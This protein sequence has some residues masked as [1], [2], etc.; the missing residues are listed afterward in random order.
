MTITHVI[1]QAI[2]LRVT[3]ANLALFSS[4][5]I[6]SSTCSASSGSDQETPVNQILLPA[7]DLTWRIHLIELLLDHMVQPQG[8]QFGSN[9]PPQAGEAVLLL[10][11]A[12]VVEDRRVCQGRTA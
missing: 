8:A 11:V 2:S 12:D 4:S 3:L 7:L 10:D 9:P 1:L 5:V 6:S